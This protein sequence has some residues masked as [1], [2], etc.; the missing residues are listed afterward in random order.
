MPNVPSHLYP[1]HFIDTET[2]SLDPRTG[3]IIQIAIITIRRPDDNDRQIYNK[4]ITMKCP[5]Q[6]DPVSLRINN[7]SDEAWANSI[8]WGEAVET[9]QNILS[10]GTIIGHNVK[11]DYQY[12]VE[13]LNGHRISH[14]LID[15]QMLMMEHLP[16]PW[17][18]LKS[19]RIF[20]GWGSG[21]HDALID[22]QN[23]LRLFFEL[24]RCCPVKRALWAEEWEKKQER[25]RS[26]L[27][28][29]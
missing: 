24:W 22:A 11:F 2:T 3:E 4:K 17:T 19:A 7:Y 15:T 9:I 21:A 26:R 12:I 14:R 1:L 8:P 23:T 20:F 13:G 10:E 28:N 27:K 29:G 25:K 18:S 16:I 5:E 6:A